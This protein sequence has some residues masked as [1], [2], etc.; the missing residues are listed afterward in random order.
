MQKIDFRTANRWN[1]INRLRG[2]ENHGEKMLASRAELTSRRA[3]RLVLHG[4][5]FS[6]PDKM[7]L[8]TLMSLFHLLIYEETFNRPTAKST[9]GPEAVILTGAKL[10][11]SALASPARD[12][13]KPRAG[14]SPQARGPGGR[15]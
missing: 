2:C 13:A 7:K 5:R 4:G 1:D 9:L 15:F 3:P 11:D 12:T 8:G 6:S 14:G 10:K